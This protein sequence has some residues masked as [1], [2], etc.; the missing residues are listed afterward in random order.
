MGPLLVNLLARH[1]FE[2]ATICRVCQNQ[3]TTRILDHIELEAYYKI[4]QNKAFK[5]YCCNLCNNRW[6]FV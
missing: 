6:S 3:D 5:V 4:Y 1:P 2:P